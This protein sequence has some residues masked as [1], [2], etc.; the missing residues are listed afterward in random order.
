[1]S[2]DAPD[3]PPG[4]DPEYMK[5]PSLGGGGGAGG[6]GAAKIVK[7]PVLM[8]TAGALGSETTGRKSRS[9]KHKG[10]KSKRE[11]RKR[12]SGGGSSGGGKLKRNDAYVVVPPAPP[13][14]DIAPLTEQSNLAGFVDSQVRGLHGVNSKIQ[15]AVR[16]LHQQQL[17]T[18]SYISF[19]IKS[20][21]DEYIR[22]KPDSLSLVLYSTYKNP[23]DPVEGADP[24]IPAGAARHAVRSSS[25]LPFMFMDPSVMAT[26]LFSRVETL[27]DNVPVNSNACL[28]NLL[29][30][31]TR[32]CDVFGGEN[33]AH[34]K[35]T[36]EIVVP[37][38]AV[39]ISTALKKG[40][41]AFDHHTWNNT[42]GVRVKAHLRGIFPFDC[43]NTM[44]SAI[45]N[46]KEPNYYF[47]PDT[48]FEFRLHY[49]PDKFASVFHPDL[50]QNITEYFDPKAKVTNS[51][52][53]EIAYVI[54]EAS[55]EYESVTLK[56][57]QHKLYLDRFKSGGSAVY[58]YDVIRGQHVGLLKDAS[59][60]DTVFTI[61]PFARI[62]VVM[63]VPDWAVFSMAGLNRPLSGF[64]TYPANCTKMSATLGAGPPLLTESF[65]RFGFPGEQH[66]LSKH[67]HYNY[68]TSHHVTR[69][70]F[71]DFFPPNATDMPL[72]QILWFNLRD[73]M[74]DKAELFNLKCEFAGGKPSPE[75]IQ[76]VVFSVHPTGQV[77]CYH[78]GGE[79]YFDW[80]WEMK[81]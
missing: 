70:S 26:G 10:K 6:G 17:T 69:D 33:T 81:F 67:F 49:H 8:A 56:Q 75:R 34:L 22:F 42:K 43:K 44:I 61:M 28:G 64:S 40:C 19:H 32:L 3:M 54:Q 71:D 31:Y 47:P 78:A 36:A 23:V 1:M 35:N 68:S 38:P 14:F 46:L 52:D 2:F 25:A 53:K 59:T 24:M 11:K 4:V 21:R 15:K 45:E 20:T 12:D 74:S 13:V 7:E 60:T 79:G 72:N 73:R 63:F 30:Q 48:S 16:P 57:E 62:L 9:K 51:S 80:R 41:T 65:E 18:E 39:K 5:N 77:K 58:H 37:S 76:V 50:A 29:L 55:L 66:Q 27:I